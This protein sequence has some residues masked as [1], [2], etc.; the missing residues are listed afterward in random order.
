M[1]NP[2][3]IYHLTFKEIKENAD[4]L[5]MEDDFIKLFDKKIKEYDNLYYKYMENAA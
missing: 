3:A 2:P 1:N 4:G 5:C